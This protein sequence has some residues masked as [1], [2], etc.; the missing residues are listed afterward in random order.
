M[1]RR[2]TTLWA[3]LFAMAAVFHGYSQPGAALTPRDISLA[4]DS[5]SSVPADYAVQCL[6]VVDSATQR[7]VLWKNRMASGIFAVSTAMAGIGCA[8]NSGKTPN[9]WHRVCEWIGD[10][11]EPGRVFVSRIPTVEI[12]PQAGWRA[13]SG[14]DK[15]LTRIM[16]L[17][18]LEPGVNSGPGVDSHDRYIYLHG[19]NQEQLLGSPASH[20][21][22]RLSN[23][24]IM[25]LFDLTKGCETL[26]RIY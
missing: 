18:G 13:S 4:Q 24:D 16:W 3:L 8:E 1:T 10:G 19:T 12:I 14:E 2:L 17:E 20:G 9:G 7:L 23:R 15:V 26:C 6:I 5:L 21:C 11:A 22:I 25:E